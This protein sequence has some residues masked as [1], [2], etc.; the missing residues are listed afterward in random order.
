MKAQRRIASGLGSRH[1]FEFSPRRP[2]NRLRVTHNTTGVWI[3]AARDNYSPRD[4]LVFIHYLAEEGFIPDRYRTFSIGIEGAGA[5]LKW[6]VEQPRMGSNNP[7]TAQRANAF[8]IRLLT[9]A[10]SL[11]LIQIAALVLMSR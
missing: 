6:L 3:L 8:M 1:V 5:G 7:G 9:F 10:F 11:F 4:K 2:K